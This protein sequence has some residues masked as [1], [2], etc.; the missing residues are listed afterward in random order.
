MKKTSLLI[1]LLS[2]SA[3]SLAQDVPKQQYGTP[4]PGEK[5]ITLTVAEIMKHPN[6]VSVDKMFGPIIKETEKE[7]D[8]SHLAQDPN[9][10][11]VS[12]WPPKAPT[13]GETGG[14]N[15]GGP[16][17]PQTIGNQWTGSQAGNLFPP[18]S[19]G[20]VGP[21]QV[22]CT[23]NSQ[24]R[25]FDKNGTLGGLNVTLDSFFNSVRN[26]AG[27]SDPRA[28]FDRLSNKWY[29]CA[30]N[31]GSPFRIMLAVSSGPTITNSTSFTFFFVNRGTVLPDYPSLGVDANGV[32]IG[33]NSFQNAASFSGCNVTVIQKSSV[34]GVGPI[35]ATVFNVATAAGEGPFA[36]RGIDNDDPAPAN[37]YIIGASNIAFSRLVVRKV[38]GANTTTPTMGPNQLISVATTANPITPVPSIGQSIDALD[39]RVFHA[40]LHLN[41]KTGTRTAYL[42]HTTR[43]T[44]AGV[45]SSGGT[46]NAVRWYEVDVAAATP[47]A[48]Q[49]G[50]AYD[51]AASGF[52]HY[53]IGSCNITGQG[54]MALGFT[55]TRS[56][57]LIRI[58]S[59]GRLANDGPGNTQLPPTLAFTSPATYNPG[60]TRWGDYSAVQVDPTDDQTMWTFQEFGATATQWGV[61]VIKLVAPPPSPIAS[62]TPNTIGQGATI[63]VTVT[64]TATSGS[65]YYDTDAGYAN[66]L[67]A[68]FSGTGLTVNSIS[69]SHANPQQVVLNVTASGG[70]ATG[71]RDLTITNPDG[72]ATT[73]NSVITVTGGGP[74]TETLAPNAES[75]SLGTQN[76]GGN[77]GSWAADDNNARTICKFF[78]PN[79]ASPFIRVN[80]NFTTTKASPTAISFNVKVSNHTPGPQGLTL[81]IQDKTNSTFVPTS[82]V[83]SNIVNGTTYNGAAT[84]PLARYVGGGGAMTG[85][86]EV[87]QTGPSTQTFPC[88]SFE[89]GQMV[90]TG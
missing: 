20:A 90:V 70:A 32:Y 66:R 6:I 83:N 71:A 45:G 7:V 79:A 23:T 39:D 63:N 72:Q 59:A 34:Q 68:A 37:G 10:K 67:A 88:A 69:F 27:C 42:A 38:T 14:K 15:H 89:F 18:D 19:F 48:L 8:R 43:A 86:I 9:A 30:I 73:G 41:R 25:V 50:T 36:P 61:R 81:Y 5:G 21:T 17:S 12:Q 57:Q 28:T 31:V 65:E 35:F 40:Q 44:N 74:T 1:A 24:V 22:L 75:I 60:I 3:F 85:Q 56:G 87:L 13:Q 4:V 51:P 80:L 54:H 64:G 52:D 76:S 47:V 77:L 53:T 82:V 78:V 2:F 29:V 46:R 49:T 33:E 55:M 26:G 58:G 84:A 62:V 11:A 16:F